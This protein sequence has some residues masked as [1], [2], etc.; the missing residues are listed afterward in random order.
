[1]QKNKPQNWFDRINNFI[2]K[3][4]QKKYIDKKLIL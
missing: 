1:M 4:I 3:K 2:N